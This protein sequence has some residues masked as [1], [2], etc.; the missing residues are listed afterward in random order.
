MQGGGLTL[1]EVGLVGRQHGEEARSVDADDDLCGAGAAALRVGDGDGEG[2]R[3]LQ[4]DGLCCLR[5]GVDHQVGGFPVEVEGA[6]RACVGG[7]CGAGAIEYGGR[8]CRG[9]RGG[10][11]VDGDGLYDLVGA[12]ACSLDGMCDVICSCLGVVVADGLSV[13]SLS[14]AE[15][16][17]VAVDLVSSGGAGELGRVALADAGGVEAGGGEGIDGD[18]MRDLV[19][20]TAVGLHR[21]SHLVGAGLSVGVA[22]VL[23]RSGLVVAE[24]PLIA[25]DAL[26]RGCAGELCG[27]ALAHCGGIEAGCRLCI[28]GDGMCDL[29]RATAVGLHRESHLVSARLCVGMAGALSRSSLVVTEVPLI[30]VDA[31]PSG[32]ASKL[33][34]LALTHCG[35]VETRGWSGVDGNSLCDLV[36]ATAISLYSESHLICARLSIGMVGI[37]SRAS[38]VVTK[39]PLVAVNVLTRRGASELRGLA[40]TYR[41][42][43]EASRRLCV[44]SDGLCDV[45]STMTVA[46]ANGKCDRIGSSCGISVTCALSRTRLPITEAPLVAAY[47]L[48]AGIGGGGAGELCGAANT[49]AGGIEVGRGLCVNY[50]FGRGS[51]AFVAYCGCAS[52]GA[53]HGHGAVGTLRGHLVGCEA[54]R[55]CPAIGGTCLLVDS[56]MDSLANAIRAVVIH[57]TRKDAAVSFSN[58]LRFGERNG[59]RLLG[60][61]TNH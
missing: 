47:S 42:G 11:G 41:G 51:G 9:R 27:L 50:N 34:G 38:L 30:A 22:G 53:R 24:V 21:E 39:V 12:S 29:V 23:S 48:S 60:I 28:H 46:S 44:H 15:V 40:L 36:R 13:A 31:L 19:G 45:V 14:V 4:R 61:V 54:T 37:L 8:C 6:L 43:V 25:V 33:C 18:G 3:L 55:T 1:A 49:Y 7:Q 32:G 17:L 57:Y 52:V 59:T 10:H 2:L 16:P 20:A 35:G 58:T 5:V 26:S 56:Q